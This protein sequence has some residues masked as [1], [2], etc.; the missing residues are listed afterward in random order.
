MGLRKERKGRVKND[1]G[2]KGMGWENKIRKMEW[3]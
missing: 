2:K 3:R 1:G